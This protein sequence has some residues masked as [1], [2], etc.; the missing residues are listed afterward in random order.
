MIRLFFVKTASLTHLLPTVVGDSLLSIRARIKRIASK[1]APTV[2]V[3]FGQDFQVR[4]RLPV[5]VNSRLPAAVVGASL[6]ASPGHGQ[7]IASKRAPRVNVSVVGWTS[8]HHLDNAL[9]LLRRS[10][11]LSMS[12][13]CLARRARSE[14]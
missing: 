10:V 12:E 3:V 2:G 13:C 14:V 5:H 1:L 4:I 9:D 6:L 11:A 7:H 8:A